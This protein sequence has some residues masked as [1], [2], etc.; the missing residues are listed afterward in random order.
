[1]GTNLGSRLRNV[2]VSLASTRLV[3]ADI[4]VCI[5]K[6]MHVQYVHGCIDLCVYVYVCVF[7]CLCVRVCIV[8]FV[9]YVHVCVVDS[10][11]ACMCG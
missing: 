10:V 9:Q 2:N 5:I 7:V 8:A 4:E 1:M 11:C 3:I 6:C